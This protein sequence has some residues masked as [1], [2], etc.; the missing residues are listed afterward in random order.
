MGF[1]VSNYSLFGL[2]PQNFYVSIHGTYQIRKERHSVG[3][4]AQ[5]SERDAGGPYASKDA[6]A[7]NTY[8]DPTSHSETRAQDT[9]CYVAI[10]TIYYQASAN[11]SVIMKKE[12]CF[13]IGQLPEPANIYPMIYNEIKKNIDPDNILTITDD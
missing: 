3:N 6:R 10:Y 2:Q 1:T 7:L 11:S 9:N 4:S 8:G 12:D 5:V 13:S